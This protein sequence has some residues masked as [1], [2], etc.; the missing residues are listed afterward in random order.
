VIFTRKSEVLKIGPYNSLIQL[1]LNK[2]FLGI[3]TNSY[4]YI[5]DLEQ[6]YDLIEHRINNVNH[7]IVF[8]TKD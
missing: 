2:K 8:T 6:D 3:L 5:R 7:I 4:V 1:N